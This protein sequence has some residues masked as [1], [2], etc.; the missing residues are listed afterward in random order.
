MSRDATPDPAWAAVHRRLVGD[1]DTLT[2]T[3]MARVCGELDSYARIPAAELRAGLRANIREALTAIER[4]RVPTDGEL[5]RAAMIGRVRAEQGVPV[6]DVVRAWQIVAHELWQARRRIADE[7]TVGPAVQVESAR[8]VL[9]TI[10]RGLAAAAFGHGQPD[11]ARPGVEVAQRRR[12]LRGLVL[13]TSTA[14]DLDLLA[15]G[16]QLGPRTTC[17]AVRC[18]PDGDEHARAAELELVRAGAGLI[19]RVD[20]ELLAVLPA[21]AAPTVSIAAGLGEPAP[22]AELGRSFTEAAA[23]LATAEAF[24]LTGAM[25]P[26]VLGVKI[27]VATRPEMGDRLA[28][29]FVAPLLEGGPAG[30]TMLETVAEHL[31][32]GL[33][34]NRTAQAL[35]VHPNTVRHRL[36]RFELATGARLDDIEDV[37]ALWWALRHHELHRE[38]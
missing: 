23:A 24:G 10:D 34:V 1:L 13:G 5:G 4:T 22:P 7:L 29:R 31:R 28:A 12:L 27:A 18:R 38:R 19:E 17:R 2:E 14:A 37:V 16:Y 8:L 11:V 30:A 33:R 15:S 35:Y 26:T 36:R 25:T 3:V 9:E 32:A 6:E 20:G 21:E